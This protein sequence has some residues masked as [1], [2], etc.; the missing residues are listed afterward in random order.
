MHWRDDPDLLGTAIN[1]VADK[2]LAL[3]MW[4]GAGAILTVKDFDMIL[5]GTS[6]RSALRYRLRINMLQLLQP[7]REGSDA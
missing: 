5:A 2:H 6:C 3:P 1:A 4:R 7:S